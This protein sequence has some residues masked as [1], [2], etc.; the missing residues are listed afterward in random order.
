MSYETFVFDSYVFDESSKTLRLHYAIDDALRFTETY[1]FDFEFVDH[2]PQVLDRAFQLLFYVAGVSYYKTYLPPKI[3]SQLELDETTAQFLERTYQRGLGE[4]FY[5]NRMDPTQEIPFRANSKQSPALKAATDRTLLVGL[6]G[7]KDS[8]LSVE[9]LRKA[10]QPIATWSLNHKKQLEPLVERVGEKHYWV[11][12]S[13]DSQLGELNKADAYNG[14]VPISAIFAAVGTIVGVLRGHAAHVVSNENSANE[15]TLSY[16]GQ[17]IN[18][19]Y[20]KSQEFERDY[21]A[22]LAHHFGGS[23][24]YYSLLRPLTELR[25]A[26][27]FTTYGLEKYS[28]VFSSCNR[29]YT[30]D[31]PGLYWD[32][33]CSKCAFV[34]LIL[35]PFVSTDTLSGI[36]GH[37]LLSDQTLR[38]TYEQLL[39]IAGD[40]PL[41]CV[42]E[43][44]ESRAAMR[45]LQETYPALNQFVFDLPD[46][47]DFR[48]LR[49]HG[50]PTELYEAIKPLIAARI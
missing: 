49:G 28:G 48:T 36:I 8:L 23:F 44:K 43:I 38:S 5:V 14:H 9:L 20:S 6:G 47:Y 40:K 27:L 39:G 26:E 46:N 32:G 13:W 35:S 50:M 19:Q 31:S 4:F 11:E 3:V 29:A 2:D 12:R 16:K 41:E 1:K 17:D 10:K 18:H 24:E 30:K 33:T 7:G 34:Y 45:L 42:G 21:Q 22:L 15:P 25:V 37:N